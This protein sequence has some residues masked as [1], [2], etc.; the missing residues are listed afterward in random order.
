MDTLRYVQE[1]MTAQVV[2]AAPDASTE[3][4][5]RQLAGHRIGG[6]PVIDRSQHVLGIIVEAD[7]LDGS[8]PAGGTARDAMT[9]PAVTVTVGTTLG[10]AR[11]LMLARDIGR[12]P[13]VD[14]DGKLVGIVSRRDLLQSLLSGDDEIRRRV[15]D[16]AV[17]A[18]GEVYAITVSKGSV[19]IR[20][21]V[22]CRSEIPIL[23][24]MLRQTPGVAGLQVELSYDID[25]TTTTTGTTR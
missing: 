24:Q 23:E 19:W 11:A 13:V 1:V 9:S 2:A 14:G 21:R 6:M 15:I 3:E 12:L 25:D 17:D 18:G 5:A 22:G 20:G 7:L 10:E 4:V 16:R 8:G